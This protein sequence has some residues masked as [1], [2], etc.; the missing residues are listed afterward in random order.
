MR[1]LYR[2]QGFSTEQVPVS[3][4]GGSLKN[5]RDLKDLRCEVKLWWRARRGGCCMLG[6][7]VGI[8]K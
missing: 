8:N 2:K 5:L 3:A 7:R 1:F 6:G 4:Y